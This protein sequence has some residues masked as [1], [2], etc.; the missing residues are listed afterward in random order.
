MIQ[1]C[2]FTEA[3][4]VKKADKGRHRPAIVILIWN[5]LKMMKLS[6]EKLERSTRK[7]RMD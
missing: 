3:V 4:T 5:Y 7:M 1:L 6:F 2:K